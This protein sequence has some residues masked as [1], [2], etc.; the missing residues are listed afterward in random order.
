MNSAVLV[1]TWNGGAEAIACLQRLHQIDPA[2]DL[3]MVVDNGSHDG[4]PDQIAALFPRS[5]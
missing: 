3:V 5:R 4:T 1:L 2:P